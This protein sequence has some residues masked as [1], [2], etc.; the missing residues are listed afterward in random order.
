MQV[1][2]ALYSGIDASLQFSGVWTQ[3]TTFVS[4]SALTDI[5]QGTFQA[6][7]ANKLNRSCSFVMLFS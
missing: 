7:F 3:Y 1:D 2:R 6:A 5:V 4:G